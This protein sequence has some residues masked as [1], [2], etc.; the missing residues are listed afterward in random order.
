MVGSRRLT[1]LAEDV[2]GR[3]GEAM[4]GMSPAD[5]LVVALSG[6]ADSAVCLWAAVRWA[7]GPVEGVHVDHSLPTSRRMREAAG[8]VGDALGASVRIEVVE[9]G[10]GASPEDRARQARYG[11]LERAAEGRW[12]LTGHT[13]DDQAETV[14]GN[15]LRG[16]GLDGL[17]GIPVRRGRIVRPL[18]EVGR[19]ETRE[20][21]TLLGLAWRDDPLNDNMRIRRNVLRRTV[22]P[23]LEERFNPR[24]KDALAR[25]AAAAEGDRRVLETMV[26]RLPLVTGPAG[27]GMAAAILESVPGAVA[28]RGARRLLREAG[29]PHAGSRRDVD[30]ILAVAAG[31]RVSAPL[32]GGLTAI[33]RGALVMVVSSPEPGA[34]DM[35]TWGV[36][37]TAEYGPW[38]LEAWLDDAPPVAFP[39][40]ASS[41]V[42]D[43]DALPDQLEVRPARPGEEIAVAG[44][45]HKPVTDVLAEAGVAADL[46]SRWPVVT[47]EG[48]PIWVPGGRRG[49][50]GWVT[51]ATRRYLW[52]RARKEG[53]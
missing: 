14:L 4:S 21:A 30:M 50:V 29:G 28:A 49:D 20:L 22:L 36:P 15:L 10:A 41:V 11:A 52:A 39:L 8:R 9:V 16:A 19:D 25:T 13:R 40:G 51:A 38:V 17:A 35:V 34:P 5:G 2:A 18:L 43:A 46:R 53:A 12:I 48:R 1:D 44:V 33:R 7:V 45:G 26:Q 32:G 37:G 24:L 23:D 3:F 27:V 6:G 31:R 42:W 47:A